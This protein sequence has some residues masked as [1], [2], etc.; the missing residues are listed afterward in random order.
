M[1][2][3]GSRFLPFQNEWNELRAIL[4][5]EPTDRAVNCDLLRV[6]RRAM[7]TQFEVA[8]PVFPNEPGVAAASDALDIIDEI[9]QE[10]T[11]YREDSDISAVNRIADRELVPVPDR[12]FGLLQRCAQLTRLTE[13]AFDIA[14]GALIRTWGFQHRQGR[15]PTV[16]ERRDAMAATGMRFVRLDEPSR[17]VRFLR[18]GVMLNFGA[19][20]KGFALDQAA[21]WLQG[22]WGI[23]SG[24]LHGGSSSI[25]AFGGPPMQNGWWVRIRH[26]WEPERHLGEIRLTNQA[27]GT[28]AATYQFFEHQRKRYGHI[29][30]PRQGRPAEGMAQVSVVAADAATADAISTALYVLGIDR[31]VQFCRSHPE[32]G[33]ILLPD[34][35]G[36]TPIVFNISRH[37]F[38]PAGQTSSTA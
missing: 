2:D 37:D 5:G 25:L 11:I 12:V 15:I 29:L 35:P 23:R 1:T 6:S 21:K 13:G 7:A 36:A 31:A 10:L 28:S 33:A 17:G 9:E 38:L 30:D 4:S 3:R 18:P 27:L 20:G 14:A 32:I 24:M 22:Q 34:D 26:P 8:L 16:I 19:I